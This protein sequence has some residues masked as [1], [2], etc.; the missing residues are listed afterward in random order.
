[1]KSFWPGQYDGRAIVGESFEGILAGA[2]EAEVTARYKEAV[3]GPEGHLQKVV[4]AWV[5]HVL[6]SS[7]MLTESGVPALDR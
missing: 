3:S 5:S 7:G 4:W 2:D 1:M 6:L